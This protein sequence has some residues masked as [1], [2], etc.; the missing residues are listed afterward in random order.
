MIKFPSRV[1]KLVTS[2]LWDTQNGS[3]GFFMGSKVDL[4]SGFIHTTSLDSIIQVR[5][6]HF[7]NFDDKENELLIAAINLNNINSRY[8]KWKYPYCHI[9]CPIEPNM[10][11]FI[12]KWEDIGG[13]KD[14]DTWQPISKFNPKT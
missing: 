14:K 9:H 6:K 12:Y 5:E 2:N 11:D 10:I 13:I 4:T 8:I 1:F 3:L 7:K